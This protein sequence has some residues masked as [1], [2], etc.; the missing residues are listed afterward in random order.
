MEPE[1]RICH[2]CR[3]I[4][5]SGSPCHFVKPKGQPMRWYCEKCV[6]GG[7]KDD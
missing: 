6:K 2:I 4:I 5:V 7:K 3:E 1:F